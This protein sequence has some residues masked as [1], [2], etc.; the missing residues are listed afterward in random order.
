M[1]IQGFSH[2]GVCVSD[3]D[4]S[5]RFYVDVLGFEELFTMDM[6]DEVA[7]TMEMD[8]PI[9][10]RSRMLARDDVRVEL[11]HWDRARGVAAIGERRPM[12]RFGLTHLCIRVDD[13]EDLV[14]AAVAAGGAVH[15][16]TLSVLEGAGVGGGP[17]KLLYLTDPDG[18][19]VELMSGTPDLSELRGRLSGAE[20]QA[21]RPH[22][23]D[24]PSEPVEAARHRRPAGGAVRAAP[25]G[26][27]RTP[28][29][30]RSGPTAERRK[31]EAEHQDLV[32]AKDDAVA[33]VKAL[34]RRDRVAPGETAE[35][36][37]AYKA[38][39]AALIE[40]ETGAP[41]PWAATD[42]SAP[43]VDA[44]PDPERA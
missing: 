1:G 34:R 43:D 8:A 44:Q 11:L 3:L 37:A 31:Q 39:L 9:S 6:G 25:P 32:K 22:H 19:R 42:E 35:A 16:Q 10:F 12:D 4:R 29:G 36:D 40:F 26:G 21:A 14:D 15:R 23:D 7:A 20:A 2:V 17:V 28:E 5:T 27:A 18:T 38:A 30:R 13:V 33:R 24:R 41:P